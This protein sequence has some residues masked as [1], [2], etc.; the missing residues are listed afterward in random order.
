MPGVRISR[1]AVC[2]SRGAVQD[3]GRDSRGRRRCRARLCGSWLRGRHWLRA[4]PAPLAVL[5]A[6]YSR[7][8]TLAVHLVVDLQAGRL[9]VKGDWEMSTCR[10]AAGDATTLEEQPCGYGGR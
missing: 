7:V 3:D 10:A 5:D 2:G 1:R 9:G 8:A 6:L 4:P